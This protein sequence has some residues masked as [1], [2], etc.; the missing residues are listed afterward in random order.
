MGAKGI[1]KKHYSKL[2]AFMETIVIIG[3]QASPAIAKS[4]T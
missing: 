1:N 3:T 4:T 2:P